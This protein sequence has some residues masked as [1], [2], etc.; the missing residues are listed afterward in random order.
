MK[1]RT[2]ISFKNH[3]LT[4]LYQI[5]NYYLEM[6]KKNMPIDIKGYSRIGLA[7]QSSPPQLSPPQLG[8]L[9]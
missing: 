6:Q 7:T 5:K 3:P 9:A 4:Y 8:A 1:N 2:K